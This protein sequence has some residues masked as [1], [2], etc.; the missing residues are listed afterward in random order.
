M[1]TYISEL[2]SLERVDLLHCGA[3]MSLERN[4]LNFKIRKSMTSGGRKEDD[5]G[6]IRPARS[7]QL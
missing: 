6:H 7:D 5:E 4:L 3:F 2:C 1:M